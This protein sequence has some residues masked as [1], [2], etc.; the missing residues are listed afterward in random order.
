[1]KLVACKDRSDGLKWECRKQTRGKRHKAETSIRRGSWFVQSNMTLEEILKFTH[2]WCQD[3]EQS[4]ITRELRLARGTG[5][6]WDSFCREV[7][8]ITMFDSS[9]KIGGEGK[10]VQMMKANLE[11]ENIIEAITSKDN[12]CLVESSRRVGNVLWWQWTK[13][14]K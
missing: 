4:Q 12:G 5:V 1:M 11:S 6:D 8:E 14:T 10:I 13:E 7:C 9:Q 3:L 2:W